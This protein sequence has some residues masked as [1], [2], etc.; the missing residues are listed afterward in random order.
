[1]NNEPKFL[2]GQEIQWDYTVLSIDYFKPTDFSVKG[3]VIGLVPPGQQWHGPKYWKHPEEWK[4]VDITVSGSL[5]SKLDEWKYVILVLNKKWIT[6]LTGEHLLLVKE[7][8]LE[9]SNG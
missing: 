4:G 3:I 6:C 8:S 2:I 7:E 5:S 9:K 1:M